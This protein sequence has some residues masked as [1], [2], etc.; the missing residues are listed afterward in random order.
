[1][2]ISGW[3]SYTYHTVVH[4]LEQLI[5]YASLIITSNSTENTFVSLL[6]IFFGEQKINISENAGLQN[7]HNFA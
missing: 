3:M 1:M 4:Y 6:T 2:K 5:N 7:K